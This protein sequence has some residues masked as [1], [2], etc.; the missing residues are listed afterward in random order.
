MRRVPMYTK[1]YIFSI[2]KQLKNRVLLLLILQFFPLASCIAFTLMRNELFTITSSVLFFFVLILV[3]HNFILPLKQY[4]KFLKLSENNKFS[5][6]RGKIKTIS[7]ERNCIEGVF[8]TPIIL[9]VGNIN[10]SED[11]RLIYFDAN[12]PEPDWNKSYTY[13][14]KLNDKRV[15][16]YRGENI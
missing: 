15:I 5:V 1:E 4:Y 6:I 10:D 13:D 2:K 9:N 3:M 16:D 7:A 8:F 12:L 14:F 11:D